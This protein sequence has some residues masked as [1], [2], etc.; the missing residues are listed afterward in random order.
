[1]FFETEVAKRNETICG[2]WHV[3]AIQ[4]NDYLNEMLPHPHEQRKFIGMS[5]WLPY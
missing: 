2:Q 4:I 1:M 3:L 5:G